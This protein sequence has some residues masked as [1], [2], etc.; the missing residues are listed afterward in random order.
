M[1]DKDLSIENDALYRFGSFELDPSERSLLRGREVIPLT[2][3]AFDTLCVLIEN[4]GR[5]VTKAQL[6]DKVWPET[7]VE[8]KTLA[9][10]IFTLRKALGTDSEGR[11]YI[12]TVPKQGYRFS[13]NVFRSTRDQLIAD[14]EAQFMIEAEP[15]FHEPLETSEYASLSVVKR[16]LPP[17]LIVTLIAGVVWWGRGRWWGRAPSFSKIAITKLTNAGDVGPMAL[18]PDGNYV[19]YVKRG[20]GQQS[21]VVR[22]T[23]SASVLEIVPPQKIGFIGASFSPDGNTIFYVT[24]PYGGSVASVYRIPLLGGTP[25]K[26]IDD[27]DSAATVSA[28]GKQLAFI[29]NASTGLERQ[30]VIAGIDGSG[31]KILASTTGESAFGLYGPAWSPDQRLI[32]VATFKPRSQS[33]GHGLSVVDTQNGSIQ[34]VGKDEWNR[35]GHAA[36]SAGGDELVVTAA[37]GS[38]PVLVDQIWIV[39]YPSGEA[40]RITND[41]DGHFGLGLSQEQSMIASVV[42]DRQG[43]F[44]ISDLNDAMKATQTTRVSGDRS[45]RSLGVSWMADNRLVYSSQVSGSAELWTMRADGSDQR[46]LTF[47][48]RGNVMPLATADGKYIVYASGRG[49]ERGISRINADGSNLKELTQ[50]SA[51]VGLS[52]TPDSKWIVYASV[53]DQSPALM[54]VS[55]DGGESSRLSQATASFPSVSPD[56]KSVACYVISPD[57]KRRLSIISFD[58][59]EIVKQFDVFLEYNLPFL[60]WM[61]DGKAITYE[62][63]ANGVSNIWK[64]PVAGGAPEQVTRWESDVIFRFDWSRDG[65]LAVERGMFTNDI[66]L[67]RAEE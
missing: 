49:S 17:L 63:A 51:I 7:Y 20:P 32:A 36:W 22:Q 47:D 23:S 3:K 54:K 42:S 15:V 21:L 45:A 59:G 58:T 29:R 14:H 10:N 55:I 40:R 53:R 28:D 33:G 38:D 60:K 2:P 11:N 1:L 34:P 19:A 52:V 6:L 61:P 48:R 9:Q 62:V 37:A 66:I 56:G 50:G 16:L 8:E 43:A 26:V 30:L 44:W 65:R 18:S 24:R 27:A 64:Q 46:Q 13:A 5:L 39:S 57:R 67:I 41:V 31:E 4:S 12:E 35:M 25:V